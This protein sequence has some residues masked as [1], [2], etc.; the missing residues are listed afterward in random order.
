L[1]QSGMQER[2]QLV[3]TADPRIAAAVAVGSLACS[4]WNDLA[5]VVR[6]TGDPMPSCFATLSV[7]MRKSPCVAGWMSPLVVS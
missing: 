5:S 6:V 1:A 4:T 3:L 7:A 2:L